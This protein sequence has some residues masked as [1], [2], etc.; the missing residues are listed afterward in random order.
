MHKIV[1]EPKLLGHKE[2]NGQQVPV[3]S[4][5]TETVITNK[6]TNETYESEEAC[7]EDIENP[8][9]DTTEEHIQRDVKIFAPRLASLGASN[10]KE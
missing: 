8:D 1:E 7:T 2:V 4:C 3:Y 9:T 10:K 5:K 6:N